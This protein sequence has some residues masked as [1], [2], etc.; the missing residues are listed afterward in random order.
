MA[1]LFWRS[2]SWRLAL[3]IPV[4][5]AFMIPA[6]AAYA[7]GPPTLTGERLFSIGSTVMATVDCTPGRPA[8]TTWKVTGTADGPFPGTFQEIG[9]ATA[10]PGGGTVT[11]FLA[12]FRISSPAGIVTGVRTLG[13]GSE[14]FQ[15]CADGVGSTATGFTPYAARIQPTGAAT[16]RDRGRSDWGLNPRNASFVVF[17]Y[18]TTG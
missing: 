15:R 7:V 8:T 14:V 1:H 2:G 12:G 13:P 3:S 11:E 10:P 4:V 17:F 9:R 16:S 6:G 18:S 5:A